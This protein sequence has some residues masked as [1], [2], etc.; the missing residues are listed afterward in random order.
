[1]EKLTQK[2]IEYLS[3]KPNYEKFTVYCFFTVHIETQVS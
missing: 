2:L 3:G 1:M